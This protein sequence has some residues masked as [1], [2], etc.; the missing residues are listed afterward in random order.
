MLTASDRHWAFLIPAW[1]A[2]AVL[3]TY[4][5]F[6]ARNLIKQVSIDDLSV[7]VGEPDRAASD[8]RA[9]CLPAR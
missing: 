8:P 3:S 2:I 4:A 5:M 1:S 7:L 6:L 9:D